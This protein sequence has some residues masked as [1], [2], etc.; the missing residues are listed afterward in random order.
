MQLAG[1]GLTPFVTEMQNLLLAALF[2]P[3]NQRLSITQCLV[4]NVRIMQ[5]SWFRKLVKDCVCLL[6][7]LY[8]CKTVRS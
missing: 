8:D 2:R 4:K 1:S 3:L 7:L 6:C 5:T